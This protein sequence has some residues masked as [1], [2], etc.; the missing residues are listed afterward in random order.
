MSWSTGSQPGGGGALALADGPEVVLLSCCEFGCSLTFAEYEG[1]AGICPSC[2]AL[3]D[4]HDAGMHRD[5]V[6]DCRLCR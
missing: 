5:G 1:F 3:R 4:E 2:V 6:P